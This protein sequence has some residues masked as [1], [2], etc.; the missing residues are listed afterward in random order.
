MTKTLSFLLFLITFITNAQTVSFCSWNL[1]NFGKSKDDQEIQ[2]IAQTVKSF[3]IVA[4]Q[5][6]VSS[7]EG[8]K[9]VARLLDAL[10][11]TGSEWDYHLSD[12]TCPLSN[13]SERYAF[14]WK[15]HRVKLQG[16]PWLQQGE[17]AH[18]I[19]REPYFAT[20]C[21]KDKQFTIA[22]YH[23]ITKKDQPETEIKYFKQLPAMYPTL[24]LIF[25]GDFNLPQSHTV[26]NPIKSMGY[27]SALVNQKTSLRQQ[28]LPDGCLASEYDNIYYPEGAI[29]A[30]ASG[31]IHF[32]RD[33][34]T[35]QEARCISDHI[36]IYLEFKVK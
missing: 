12:P 7:G 23:A 19:E 9:A 30:V 24:K 18:L 15:K 31:V 6:V 4:I 29:I 25:A 11:R 26:F 35:V 5:E 22:N 34:V 36:P 8:A 3:D 27:K 21:I 2:F 1:Q 10:N 20:F 14:F 13:K 16:K 32:Y 17:L 33:F 28:C